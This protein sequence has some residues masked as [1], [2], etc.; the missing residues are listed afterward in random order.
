[1]IPF[2]PI[3]DDEPALEH[4]PLLKAALLTLRYIQENG[5]IGLTPS[6]ALKRYFVQWAAEAFNWPHYSASDLYQ[7]NKV[8]NELDFAPLMVLHDLLLETKL[9]RHY[10]GAMHI[11]KL[12]K[13][14]NSHPAVLWTVLANHLLFM[15]DHSRYTRY[16]DQFSADWAVILGVIDQEAKLSITQDQLFCALFGANDNS[17]LGL[18][19]FLYIHVLRPICWVG[20]M[21]EQRQGQGFERVRH[22]VKT[23][24]WAAVAVIEPGA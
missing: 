16:G 8:L 11:T 14:L 1:M 18:N 20:L 13:Q 23:S 6:K 22:F 21:E 3:T 7:L 5:P 10:K 15:F 4:S 19:S 17:N 9:V 2:K 12:G 24:L